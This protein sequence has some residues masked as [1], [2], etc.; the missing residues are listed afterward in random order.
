MIARRPSTVC[1]V[2]VLC[3]GVATI[4]LVPPSRT[5]LVYSVVRNRIFPSVVVIVLVV[6]SLSVD[7]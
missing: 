3:D 1:S 7:G 5:V 6:G 2:R 4:L